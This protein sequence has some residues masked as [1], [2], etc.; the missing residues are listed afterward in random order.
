MKAG[1]GV[2]VCGPREIAH[3]FKVIGG[4]PARMLLMCTPGGFEHFIL[5]QTTPITE[6]PS[7]PDTGKLMTLAAEYGIDIHGPLPEMPEEL[8][9]PTT[10]APDLKSLNYLWIDAFNNRDWKTERSLRAENFLAFMSGA[11]SPPG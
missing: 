6:P 7:P 2:F 1:P 4:S 5:A 8:A 10:V 11:G 3:G 9:A